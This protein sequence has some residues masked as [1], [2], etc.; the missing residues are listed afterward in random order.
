MIL[1][2]SVAVPISCQMVPSQIHFLMDVS[3]SGLSISTRKS[4]G[5][6]WLETIP[7]RM[8]LCKMPSTS[9]SP[10]NLMTMIPKKFKYVWKIFSKR[11]ARFLFTMPTL[12][13]WASTQTY[14]FDQTRLIILWN[15]EHLTWRMWNRTENLFNS[16]VNTQAKFLMLR[17]PYP[18][19][20]VL[21][22]EIWVEFL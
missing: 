8:F 17:D 18:C 12:W 19:Q 2:R 13:K 22:M 21:K 5:H 14:V 4:C 7:F 9:W 10:K 1:Q 15:S 11:R 6:F 20:R 16:K 3:L